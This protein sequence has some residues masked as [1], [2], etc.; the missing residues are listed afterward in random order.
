MPALAG[1]IISFLTLKFVYTRF[2][3]RSLPSPPTSNL[4]QIPFL[5]TFSILM[6]LGLHGTSIIKIF[7]ILGIN[8][9]IAKYGRGE[10]WNPL[11]T[12]VFNGAVLFAN[13]RNSGYR[14][15]SI[16]PALELLVRVVSSLRV[17]KRECL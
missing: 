6:L 9:A 4:H 2:F 10:K 16:H 8:Y 17:I 3:F 11:V 13:E 14:F 7:A 15:A 12:W 1:L 5:V